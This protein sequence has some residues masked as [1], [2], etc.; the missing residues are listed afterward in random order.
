MNPTRAGSRRRNWLAIIV[1]TIFAIGWLIPLIWVVLVSLRPADLPLR[2]GDIL[3]GSR[4][5]LENY[6]TAFQIAPFGK[7]YFNTIFIT[8]GVVIVQ[9][10]TV[11]LAGYAFA[12]YTFPGQNVLL[13]VVLLQVLIPFTALVVPNYATIRSLGL[14]DSRF[15]IMVPYFG[16]AFGT[17]LMRQT[18]KNV[19]RDLDDASRIDGASW[20]QTLVHVYLPAG[21]AALVAFGLA[22]ITYHWNEFL[23][24]LVV[25]NSENSRPLTVGLAIFTQL[26]ELGAQWPLVS[27]ATL[28]V[29]APLFILFLIFQRQFINSFLRSGLK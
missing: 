9:V 26:G 28:I 27:A 6:V 7:Y 1:L 10:I 15:A 4:P 22:S 18:F 17:L 16:S 11:T 25:T 8:V 24:P 29:V 20:W 12:R 13:F 19:P 23:W 3:F 5:T 2:E 21:T 14:F